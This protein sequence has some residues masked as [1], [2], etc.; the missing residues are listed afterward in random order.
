MGFMFATCDRRNA[1]RYLRKLYPASNFTG[2]ETFAA[3]FM[4]LLEADVV[5]VQDPDYHQPSQVVPG[6][7]YQT[8]DAA[9]VHAACVQ[10][11]EGMGR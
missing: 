2:D 8:I 10:L 3:D 6:T 11:H 1:V 7:N 4:K 9:V 5:R